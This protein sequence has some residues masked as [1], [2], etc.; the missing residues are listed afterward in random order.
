MSPFNFH[1]FQT[2]IKGVMIQMCKKPNFQNEGS[3]EEVIESPDISLK[4]LQETIEPPGPPQQQLKYSEM[5][6]ENSSIYST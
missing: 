5:D 4:N 3:E 6:L 2:Q 1:S